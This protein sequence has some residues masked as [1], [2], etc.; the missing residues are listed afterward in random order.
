MLNNVGSLILLLIFRSIGERFDLAK[1]T[2]SVCFVRVVKALC[3]LSQNLIKWPQENKI[4]E[5][6]RKFQ[7]TCGLPDAIG[8]VDGTYIAIKA[9][10][11]SPES[12]I[13][14]KCFYGITLQAVCDPFLQFIDCF[15]GYP[16][17]VSDNRI[18]R[19]SHI[20]EDI[21]HNAQ[22]FFPNNEYILG[23]KAYP[24]LPW[25][26][27]PYINR[28]NLTERQIYYNSVISKGRQVIER[29][30]SLLKGRFRRLKY[31][32]MNRTD[33]IPETILAACVLH[34]ICLLHPDEL[35]E[36]YINEGR[37]FVDNDD[38]DVNNEAILLDGRHRRDALANFLWDN[39]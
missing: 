37:E 13:N 35:L 2:L 32:D 7:N 29:A 22:Q 11:E 17:S 14:R 20:Y 27:T 26:M 15:V 1:S 36:Q 39:R 8:A 9:P 34:N 28:G 31:L 25:L 10:K 19:N 21:I 33:L 16:S 38:P 4:Q 18:F 6:K 30:F 5:L 23:D 24:I 3:Q 12:Y